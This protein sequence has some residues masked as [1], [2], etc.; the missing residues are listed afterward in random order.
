MYCIAS[1]PFVIATAI[2]V[3][4]R[5]LDISA[6]KNYPV[7]ARRTPGNEIK[8]AAMTINTIIIFQP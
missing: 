6:S 3:V 8:M 5:A 2:F 4:F 1:V 7:R